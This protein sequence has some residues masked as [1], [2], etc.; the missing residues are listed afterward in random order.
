[1][2]PL[3][4]MFLRGMS[5]LGKAIPA[6]APARPQQS[7]DLDEAIPFY[8]Q[9]RYVKYNLA[10]E[11]SLSAGNI[12]AIARARK[13]AEDTGTLSPEVANYMLPIAM[14]EGWGARMGVRGD[15]ANALYA[16]QRV[17]RF[18]KNMG[19]EEGK[20][21]TK[22]MIKNEPHFLFNNGDGD[23]PDVWPRAAAVY[24]AE[25]AALLGKNALPEAVV[26]RYNGAGSA[27][28]DVMGELVPANVQTYWKKVEEARRLLDHPQN[29]NL[30]QYFE[31]E[32]KR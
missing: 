10:P 17:R 21:F 3:W 23:D 22:T 28:E 2:N 4:L 7:S 24:L 6:P 8:P 11:R 27:M 29:Q 30:R 14:T 19:L 1:M 25:K 26:K 18:V 15:S 16:S 31:Q 13:L 5:E 12:T 9:E 20:H 32:Y